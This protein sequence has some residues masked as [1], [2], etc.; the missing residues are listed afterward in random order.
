MIKLLIDESAGLE[1]KVK[2]SELNIDAISIIEIMKGADDTE[3]LEFANKENR[4]IVT[5]DK[6]FGELI[7]K[8]G[9]KHRG[10][11]FLRLTI[12]SPENRFI[13]LKNIIKQFGDKLINKFCVIDETR[14]RFR[15]PLKPV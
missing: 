4:I 13:A 14:I 1:L 11:I 12:D 5:N 2:L 8:K 3:I 10:V 6:D 15:T 7:F 9:F